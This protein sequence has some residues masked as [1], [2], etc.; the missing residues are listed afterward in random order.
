MFYEAV[1]NPSPARLE[2]TRTSI[3]SCGKPHPL[4]TRKI[5]SYSQGLDH[6]TRSFDDL[7]A[8]FGDLVPGPGRPSPAERSDPSDLSTED[9]KVQSVCFNTLQN[10]IGIEIEWVS[11][12]ALHLE[13]DSGKKTLKLYQNPSFCLM[14]ASGKKACLL[15][16]LV[17]PLRLIEVIFLTLRTA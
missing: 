1:S 5:K 8:K 4:S 12:L 7:L 3:N 17:E 11:S 16:R 9:I 2:I 15:S 14:M 13:L 10:V 6:V